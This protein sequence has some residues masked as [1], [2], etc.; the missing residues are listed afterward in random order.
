MANDF[1]GDANCVAL[2]KFDNNP[3]DSKG[4]ND[5]T[6]VNTPAYDSGDKKEGTHSIDFEKGSSQYC[7][8]TDANLDA[9]FPGKSGTSEQSFSICGWFKLESLPTTIPYGIVG[10]YNYSNNQRS[11]LVWLDADDK[12]NF[13]IGYNGGTSAT[14]IIFATAC[15]VGRWYHFGVVY[16]ASDNSMKLRIWDDTAQALLDNNQTGTADGDMSPDSA[17]FEVGRYNSDTLCFDGKEDEVVVFKDVL[18]DAEIDQ[19]RA[20]TYGAYGVHEKVLTDGLQ[21]TDTLV[22]TPMKFVSDG[23]ALS[24]VLVKTP[25]KVLTD[26]IAVGD[27]LI[28][29]VSKVFTDG[30][31]FRDVISYV[32]NPT[33]LAKL[34]KKYLQLEDIG[35]G[36][37]E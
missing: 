33:K 26:G 22:K 10:K 17:P 9:G 32:K 23:V 16:D 18:S 6:E 1:S 37:E 29:T 30:I 31:A 19:I 8:I 13:S 27:V 35:G 12:V 2:W 21:L 7:T 20:G 34:I 28:K 24:D 36:G 5:L 14:A 4:G 3:N 15:Q 25:I 11:Y